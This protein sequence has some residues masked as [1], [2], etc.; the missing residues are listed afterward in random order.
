VLVGVAL[1]VLLALVFLKAPFVREAFLKLNDALV[2][3]EKATE[4]GTSL[5]FGYLGGGK[6]PFEV[7]DPASSF[8]LAFR[9]LPIVLVMSALSSLLFYWRVL[10]LL[11]RW[12]SRALEKLMGVGGVVGLSA[13]ANVFVGMVEAPLFV[14]PYLARVSRGELFAIMAGGMASIAGTVLF[15]YG[16]ILRPVIPDAVAHLLIASIL[17]APAALVV[18]FIMIPPAFSSEKEKIEFRSD[19]SGSMDALTQGTLQGAQ[20]L[21][22]I[23]AMLVVFVAL[24]AL[25]NLVIAPW[26][27]QG[28]LGWALAPLAWLCGVPWSEAP[29]AG[30][31]L[32][33]KTVI[34]E[35]V[36]YLDLSRMSG[37]SDRS[38]TLMTYALCGFANLGSLGIMIGGLGT[39][40]PERRAEIV[41][42]GI[43]SIAAGTLATC[44]TAASVALIL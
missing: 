33:T 8:V 4:A 31:L 25:V 39:M 16:S 30:A 29:A 17:S 36:A 15:L 18:A 43:K 22:N 6:P 9:A 12:L 24:V 28:M 35:L 5:V 2:I 38:R 37:L 19:A 27:L 10:P 40:C 13:A 21:L 14:R 23:V 34:N 41:A 42:L 11:V 32:G 7:S 20:L 3:L 1:Q 44:L 26:S